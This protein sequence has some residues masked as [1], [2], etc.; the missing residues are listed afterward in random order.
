M[1]RIK[2]MLF[3]TVFE[4]YCTKLSATH[5]TRVGVSVHMYRF[6]TVILLKFALNMLTYLKCTCIC[7]GCY[8]IGVN[9]PLKGEPS[10]RR[11]P[12]LSQCNQRINFNGTV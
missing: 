1:R 9:T 4:L 7:L 6:H 3:L 12:T 8:G 2:K 11:S 10:D 5:R